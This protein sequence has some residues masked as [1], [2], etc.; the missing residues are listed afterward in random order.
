MQKIDTIFVRDETK[1][2]HPVTP[3]CRAS[4]LWVFE[5]EGRATIKVDGTNVKVEAGRLYKR[6]KPTSGAYDAA[7]YVPCDRTDPA[8]RWAFEAFEFLIMSE[9]PPRD[10]IYE[11]CGPKVQG[12]PSR[13]ARHELIRVVPPLD[14]L[15]VPEDH[16]FRTW[17]GL[18]EFLA[19]SVYE[20]LVFH[21]LD[22]RMGKI[23][24]RD[25]GLPWPMPWPVPQ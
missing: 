6:Q 24:R 23:K 21:H 8:D 4:C 17:D 22:G 5:G 25:Y 14:E 20:G 2:G 1:A 13:L 12:N 18:R 3:E 16:F 11:L 7:S 10:G 9:A 19:R 15:E